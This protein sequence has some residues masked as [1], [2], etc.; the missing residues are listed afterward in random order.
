MHEHIDGPIAHD[1]TFRLKPNTAAHND[2]SAFGEK[3]DP[4]VS[5]PKPSYVTLQASAP[6]GGRRHVWFFKSRDG[7]EQA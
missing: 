5:F 1:T 3:V 6:F 2:D 4:K 7:T